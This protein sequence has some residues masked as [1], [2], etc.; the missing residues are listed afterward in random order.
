MSDEAVNELSAAY[1]NLTQYEVE[2]LDSVLNLA[3]GHARQDLTPSQL[4]IVQSLPDMWIQ[5]IGGKLSE[6]ERD[7]AL[8]F[9]DVFGQYSHPAPGTELLACY[10]S[11]VAME[12]F[13]RSLSAEGLLSIG[14]LHPTFDNIPDI[15]RGVGATLFPVEEDDLH[16]RG[17]IDPDV[18]ARVDAIFLTTPNNPTGQV[19]DAPMLAAIARQCAAAEVILTLDTCFRG[20]DARAQYDHYAV[21]RESGCRWVVIEDTGKLWP[22]LELKIGWLAWSK[23]VG[24]P[25]ERIYSDILLGISPVVMK[26]VQQFA[27]DAKEG[28]LHA[29]HAGMRENRNILRNTLHDLVGVDFPDPDNRGSVERIRFSHLES[30]RVWEVL[31]DRNVHVLPCQ[32]FHWHRPD[33]GNDTVRV[34]LARPAHKVRQTAE[35]LREVIL[36]LG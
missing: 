12:I 34:A 25:V 20:F 10:S 22:T 33:D 6:I 36:E 13:A 31:R 15:L 8:Q 24:I 17:C 26:M 27:R 5:S 29:L 2:A 16:S 28:G 7:S 3:D 11:S 19:I 32:K 35:A 18:L 21:L 14:L 4:E 9:F 30:I 23:N 1:V